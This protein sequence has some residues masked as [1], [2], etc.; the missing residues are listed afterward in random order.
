MI[1]DRL[2][3]WLGCETQDQIIGN[4]IGIL[5]RMAELEELQHSPAARA[6]HVA[7]RTGALVT[8]AVC[9]SECPMGRGHCTACWP[10]EEC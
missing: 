9:G 6:A 8:C 3:R 1:R 10:D 5:E 2:R 4:I 7:A